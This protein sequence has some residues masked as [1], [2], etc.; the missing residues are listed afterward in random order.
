MCCVGAVLLV[1]TII[2]ATSG[3]TSDEGAPTTLPAGFAAGIAEQQASSVPPLPSDGCSAPQ[4]GRGGLTGSA[5]PGDTSA[6]TLNVDGVDRSFRVHLPANYLAMEPLP[7]VFNFHGWGSSGS[8]QERFTHM[9][10]LADALPANASFIAVYPDAMG[11]LNAEAMAA[12]GYTPKAWN[13]GG[14]NSSPVC[15]HASKFFLARGRLPSMRVLKS[16]ECAAG[17]CW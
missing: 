8:G 5:V 15:L 17:S 4:L 10:D 6:F 12:V 14:C 2:V 13:G 3:A 9:S 1:G 7:L 16:V 11:D